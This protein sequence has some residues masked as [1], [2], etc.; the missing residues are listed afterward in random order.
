M[1]GSR[2]PLPPPP[3]DVEQLGDAVL[4]RRPIV[5]EVRRL[6]TA[7]AREAVHRDGIRPSQRLLHLLALL[8]AA[9]NVRADGR[10][11]TFAPP[12]LTV[13]AMRTSETA[14]ALGIGERQTRRLAGPLGARRTATGWAFDR[15]AVDAAA[16]GRKR[17]V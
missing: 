4:L 12:P 17:H 10:S 8:D 13:D 6:L 14:A 1:T 7:A 16:A 9:G 2:W 3:P 11:V 15:R 5:A